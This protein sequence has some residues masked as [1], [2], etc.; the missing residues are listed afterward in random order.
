MRPILTY[1]ILSIAAIAV[2][3]NPGRAMALEKGETARSPKGDAVSLGELHDQI[4]SALEGGEAKEAGS[5]LRLAQKTIRITKAK[6]SANDRAEWYLLEARVES[7]RGRHANAT[8]AAMKLVIL[9]P[10]H[11]RVPEGLLWAARGYEEMD[12]LNKAIDL[13]EECLGRKKLNA[14]LR[15]NAKESLRRLRERA[16]GQ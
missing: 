8:L 15:V 11:A 6:L 3:L 1:S 4:V 16:A 14:V 10:D 13:Y 12:R 5:L 7:A 9:M 2:Q